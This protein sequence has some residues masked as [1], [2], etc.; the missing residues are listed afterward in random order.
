M[1]D[2]IRTKSGKSEGMEDTGNMQDTRIKPRS[3]GQNS[4]VEGLDSFEELDRISEKLSVSVPVQPLQRPTGILA[5]T[6][7][8]VRLLLRDGSVVVGFLQKRLW[9]YVHLLNVE[10]TGRDYK[11]TSDWC[12]IEIGT[13]S[14]VYPA[15][16]RVEPIQKS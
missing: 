9:N 10:E 8:R 3:G 1:K 11:L 16:A 6:G 5:Y 15:S 7:Q 2:K 12:D 4:E 14:R 13:I